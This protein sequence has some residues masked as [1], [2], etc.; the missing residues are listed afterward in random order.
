M[1]SAGRLSARGVVAAGARHGLI[2]SAGRLSAR[3][4]GL[5]VMSGRDLL[6]WPRVACGAVCWSL[7]ATCPGTEGCRSWGGSGGSPLP[8]R[9]FER[10]MARMAAPDP[11]LTEPLGRSPAN[12]HAGLGR[13]GR[14]VC[15]GDAPAECGGPPGGYGREVKGRAA[16]GSASSR[17]P[18]ASS[19]SLATRRLWVSPAWRGR[20]DSAGGRSPG[21]GTEPLPEGAPAIGLSGRTGPG[22]GD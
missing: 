9:T 18:S 16:R 6:G 11:L 22:A 8:M 21:P 12:G 20:W 13:T 4:A 5:L 15:I 19:A 3:G 14:V 10:Q 2:V 7:P 1:V 17:A